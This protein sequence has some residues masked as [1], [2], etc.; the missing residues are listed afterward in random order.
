MMEMPVNNAAFQIKP[1]LEN[2]LHT[3]SVKQLIQKV[4]SE[5]LLSEF[6]RF[7]KFNFN[8]VLKSEVQV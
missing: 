2:I 5:T 7:L 8:C 4:T 6:L 1:T 3:G